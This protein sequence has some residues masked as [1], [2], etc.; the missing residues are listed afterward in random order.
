M[1]A[2]QDHLTASL[3]PFD[4]PLGEE[5]DEALEQRIEHLIDDEVQLLGPCHLTKMMPTAVQ[6]VKSQVSSVLWLKRSRLV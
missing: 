6:S 5:R 1:I 2:I 3:P 4:F